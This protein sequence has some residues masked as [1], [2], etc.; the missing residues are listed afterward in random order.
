MIEEMKNYFKS[1]DLKYKKII[2]TIELNKEEFKRIKLSLQENERSSTI[3]KEKLS[4]IKDDC[5]SSFPL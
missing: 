5:E 2:E 3:T 4:R 1:N